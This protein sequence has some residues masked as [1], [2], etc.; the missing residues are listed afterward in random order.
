MKILKNTFFV[1]IFVLIF[2]LFVAQFYFISNSF[3]RDTNTYL[4]LLEGSGKI[5]RE[6]DMIVVKIWEKNQVF[7]WDEISTI[8]E[9][10]LA[11][12]QWWDKSITRLAG[13]SKVVIQENSVA[14][15]L[16]Q[17]H[18]SF[19]LL[20]W[21]TWSNVVSI[22]WE[23]SYFQQQAQESVAAVRWTVF[24]V[25]ADNDFILVHNHELQIKTKAG[26]EVKLQ[27]G[28]AFSLNS[29]EFIENIKALK[30]TAWESLNTKLDEEYKQ[31]LR[32]EL[33]QIFQKN[34]PINFVKNFSQD[35]KILELLQENNP[36][37]LQSYIQSL[38][39][40]QQAEVKKTLATF[41][42][43][44][45][46]EN[47][48][49]NRWYTMKTNAR[50]TLISQSETAEKELYL[51]YVVYDIQDLIGLKNADEL[52][53]RNTSILEKNKEFLEKNDFWFLFWVSN[54][55]LQDILFAKDPQKMLQD[56]RWA[57]EKIDEFWQNFLNTQW[58]NIVN[59]QK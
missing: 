47:W 23:K 24:E 44:L 10:S 4:T 30:D 26:S 57:L 5:K 58:N 8:G 37:K 17:I 18:I 32:E 35:Q 14:A 40:T 15:D 52:I 43:M 46:F 1:L 59:L 49:D 13:N 39:E 33:T 28:Q 51:R 50:E 56:L 25:D 21:K 29:F 22:L 38:P 11:V 36:T 34:N 19:E 7:V 54:Q 42:Q 48:E 55:T 12:I 9:T 45:A 20:K 3:Q 41:H 16:S 2:S 53:Q 27:S 6:P 31:K